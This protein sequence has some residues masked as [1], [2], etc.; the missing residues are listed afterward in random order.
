M[1]VP[2]SNKHNCILSPLNFLSGF[3][4]LLT[5]CPKQFHLE[6]VACQCWIKQSL[7]VKPFDIVL[8]IVKDHK[9]QLLLFHY[10]NLQ[11]K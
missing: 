6:T 7:F 10:I 1:L 4:C 11:N 2:L 8:F 9:M 5:Y 3:S